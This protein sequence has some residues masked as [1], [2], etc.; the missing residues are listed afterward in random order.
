M[1]LNRRALPMAALVAAGLSCRVVVAQDG[2]AS[3]TFY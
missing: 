3:G 2:P 1:L